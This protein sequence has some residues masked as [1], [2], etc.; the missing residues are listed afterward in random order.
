MPRGLGHHHHS[1]G[2]TFI[3]QV[4]ISTGAIDVRTSSNVTL[5]VFGDTFSDYLPTGILSTSFEAIGFSADSTNI[6]F[7]TASNRFPQSDYNAPFYIAYNFANGTLSTYR[8]NAIGNSYGA[9]V[10][11]NVN[12]TSYSGT[13]LHGWTSGF[14]AANESASVVI[15][16]MNSVVSLDANGN[17]SIP[18]ALTAATGTITNNF[19]VG[20]ALSTTGSATIGGPFSATG[21]A[22]FAAPMT[23]TNTTN[24]Q[25]TVGYSSSKKVT[26]SVDSSGD[27]AIG[28]D[29]AVPKVLLPQ[30]SS[31][32]ES[33]SAWAFSFGGTFDIDYS[34]ASPMGCGP[35]GSWQTKAGGSYRWASDA[36]NHFSTLDTGISRASAGV[37]SFDTTTV[38]DNLGS[39]VMAGLTLGGGTKILKIKVGTGTLATGSATISDA[40]HYVHKR[41]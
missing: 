16:D 35:D 9:K 41:N 30:N 28:P 20:G 22:T 18:N 14:S 7:N 15:P 29:M 32:G 6:T 4:Q 26:F 34:T 36:T 40:C 10:V 1:T 21:S 2:D 37:V 25:L 3:G 31:L 38:G 12:G 11:I 39:A 13:G 8:V 19:K 24:P 33:T 17:A 23:I 5:N 27:L